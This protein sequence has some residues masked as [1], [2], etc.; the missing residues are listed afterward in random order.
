MLAVNNQTRP[1]SLTHIAREGS[2]KEYKDALQARGKEILDQAVDTFFQPD[3][4][5][6]DARKAMAGLEDL[7]GSLRA[8]LQRTRTITKQNQ[9]ALTEKSQSIE[10]G[11]DPEIQLK[12]SRQEKVQNEKPLF[13]VSQYDKGHLKDGKIVDGRRGWDKEEIRVARPEHD[14]MQGVGRFLADLAGVQGLYASVAMV[15][16][17]LSASVKTMAKE[18]M[19]AQGS[20]SSQHSSQHSSGAVGLLPLGIY[21]SSGASQGSASG[22]HS[23]TYDKS[24]VDE[25]VVPVLMDLKDRLDQATVEPATVISL[26]GVQEAREYVNR[27]TWFGLSSRDQ[28]LNHGTGSRRELHSQECQ[29]ERLWMPLTGT[30]QFTT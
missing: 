25:R 24:T 23:L 3:R 8:H 10:S 14:D 13:Y 20:F 26:Q 29:P 17:P 12:P 6:E 18:M 19:A 7:E 2:A 22:S 5:F 9:A 16:G 15:P 11:Q 28:Y 27:P 21:G 30:S 4:E 1:T